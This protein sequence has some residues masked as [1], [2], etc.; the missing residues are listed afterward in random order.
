MKFSFT[1]AALALLLLAAAGCG[2]PAVYTYDGKP[3]RGLTPKEE[4]V[5]ID[6]ARVILMERTHFTREEDIEP[7]K[8][9]DPEFYIEYLGDR[10]GTARIR[11]EVP[12]YE[13]GVTFT[14]PFLTKRMACYTTRAERHPEGTLVFSEGSGTPTLRRAK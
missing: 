9:G 6:A 11:F 2:G 12:G 5:L 7:L 10:V 3:C 8:T 14:G 13:Y 1:L 4:Q